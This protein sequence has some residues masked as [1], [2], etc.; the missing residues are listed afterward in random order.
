MEGSWREAERWLV[1]LWA[2]PEVGKVY[3]PVRRGRRR[4]QE[5]SRGKRACALCS[6]SWS[7]SSSASACLAPFGGNVREPSMRKQ[8]ATGHVLFTCPGASRVW[9]ELVRKRAVLG[10][11]RKGLHSRFI[12]LEL[13]AAASASRSSPLFLHHPP[14][15][16]GEPALP[17]PPPRPSRA[18]AR[19]SALPP[20]L[21]T[22]SPP[23][24]VSSAPAQSTSRNPYPSPSPRSPPTA[25]S[26]ARPMA[27]SR[28]PL[29]R[30]LRSRRLRLPLVSAKCPRL[31]TRSPAY[32]NTTVPLFSCLLGALAR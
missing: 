6:S 32:H 31:S 5:E 2:M 9:V 27:A 10:L 3:Q 26:P 21:P 1:R 25:R 29:Q 11:T 18:V 28:L 13:S 17:A 12:S 14:C 22:R 23:R 4:E 20:P 30:S 16:P 8:T 19:P 24:S 7:W 15:H